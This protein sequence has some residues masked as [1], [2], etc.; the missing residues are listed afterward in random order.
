[1]GERVSKKKKTVKGASVIFL[2]FFYEIFYFLFFFYKIVEHRSCFVSLPLLI[3]V[4]QKN[5][6]TII[7]RRTV[8]SEIK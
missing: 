8:N 5:S 3:L 1:M 7:T 6:T 2:I 4:T